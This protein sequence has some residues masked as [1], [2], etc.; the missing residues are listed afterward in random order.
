MTEAC[1]LG[2]TSGCENWADWRRKYELERRADLVAG[3]KWPQPAL[4]LTC[5]GVAKSQ[6]VSTNTDLSKTAGSSVRPTP[7]NREVT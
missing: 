4:W 6:H 2:L 5:G 3:D 7:R 1:V